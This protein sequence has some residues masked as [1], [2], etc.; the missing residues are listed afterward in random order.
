MLKVKELNTFNKKINMGTEYGEFELVFKN[1]LTVE[2]EYT[3]YEDGV[4]LATVWGRRY[5][6]RF[7]SL[8]RL[9]RFI[10]EAIA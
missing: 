9:E 7:Q 10:E 4:V 1:G 6:K 2:G 3:A 8:A 5:S